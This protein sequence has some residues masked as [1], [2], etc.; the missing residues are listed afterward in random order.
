MWEF[1]LI[2]LKQ[3]LI[4]RKSIW[5]IFEAKTRNILWFQALSCEHWTV[6]VIY[7]ASGLLKGQNKLPLPIHLH[8]STN[9][10]FD[11]RFQLWIS[12]SFDYDGRVQFNSKSETFIYSRFITPVSQNIRT[13]RCQLKNRI[14][15]PGMSTFW[16]V[17]S[18]HQCSV[19]WRRSSSGPAEVSHGQQTGCS[20]CWERK[21]AS[22]NSMETLI[23]F[24]S[25][26]WHLPIVLKL[27]AASIFHFKCNESRT[28]ESLYFW[29]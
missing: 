13:T 20:S 25:R 27:L 3:M 14:H 23:S 24:S 21:S 6:N 17:R 4:D 29:N 7:L 22:R 26:T 5:V 11:P 12:C 16:N 10:L 2:K 19:A 8:W 18:M 15:S 9:G 1:N 28:Y